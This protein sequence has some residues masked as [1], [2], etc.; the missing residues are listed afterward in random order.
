MCERSPSDA[1]G[2]YIVQRVSGSRMRTHTQYRNAATRP[3]R[4]RGVP[5]PNSVRIKSPRFNAAVW[6]SARLRMFV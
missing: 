6:I 5:T 1:D 2:R 3:W 4:L